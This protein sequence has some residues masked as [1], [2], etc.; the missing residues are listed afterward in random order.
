MSRKKSCD[1]RTAV[2]CSVY[3]FTVGPETRFCDFTAEDKTITIYALA[4]LNT[5]A[6][7]AHV[8]ALEAEKENLFVGVSGSE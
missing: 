7:M 6:L 4:E 5:P 2:E 1:F 8:R 3:F